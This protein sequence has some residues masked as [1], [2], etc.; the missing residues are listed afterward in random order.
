MAVLAVL[1]AL[2]AV[3]AA[4]LAALLAV[5]SM[6]GFSF[7]RKSLVFLATVGVFMIR[8]CETEIITIVHNSSLI[9]VTVW[10]L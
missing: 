3:L 7:A 6:A 10:L 5:L 8:E 2:L 4:L 9:F 1:A